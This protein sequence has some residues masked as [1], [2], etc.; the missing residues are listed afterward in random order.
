MN[1]TSP[2]SAPEKLYQKSLKLFDSQRFPEAEIAIAEAIDLDTQNSDYWTL[3]GKIWYMQ[4]RFDESKD[5]LSMALQLNVSNEIALEFMGSVV[6]KQNNKLEALAWF[7]KAFDITKQNFGIAHKLANHYFQEK[8]YPKAIYY[9]NECLKLKPQDEEIKM[10]MGTAFYQLGDRTKAL[11]IFS[12]VVLQNSNNINAKSS[13]AHCYQFY[14][15]TDFSEDGYKAILICLKTEKLAHRLLS[16]PWASL[17]ATNPEFAPFRKFTDSLHSKD[18][19]VLKNL[20]SEFLLLGL[21]K[22]YL[23][24]APTEIILTN[25]RRDLL[26]NWNFYKNNARELLPFLQALALVCWYNEFVF[27]QEND[28]KESLALLQTEILNIRQGQEL[29]EEQVAQFCLLCSYKP[30][31]SLGD[32]VQHIKLSK[33]HHYELKN[34]LKTQIKNPLHEIEVAQTIKGFTDISDETS[35][36]VRAMYEG[37]PYPRWRAVSKIAVGSDILERADNIDLLVAGCG[38]GHEPMQYAM[39]APRLKITAIDLSLASMAYG[40]RMAEEYGVKIIDFRHGDLMKVSDLNKKFDVITSSGVLHH[41]KEPEKG[42]EPLVKILKQGGRMSISLYSQTARD[43]VLNPAADYIVEKGY[44]KSE[45]DIRQFRKDI[46]ALPESDP[47]KLCQSSTDFYSLSECTDLL[48]HVQEH[49]YTFPKIRAMVEKYG[50]ELHH[51]MVESV[52]TKVY[53]EMFPDD[54]NMLNWDHWHEFEQKHPQTFA[55]MYK[56]WLKFKGDKSEH[57]MDPLIRIGLL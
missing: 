46:M 17:L 57:P 2:A 51:V 54:P 55:G 12:H 36:A 10:L 22:V 49:R 35:L 1:S 42:F 48:F 4:S 38:T 5:A 9:C 32:F 13:L 37:R 7:E 33:K 15:H 29:T 8:I 41:L 47:R 50:L 27:Y 14:Q 11:D 39:S 20:N 52:V 53:K 56:T 21:E 25:I 30:A 24:N 43:L 23:S 40:K 26:L 18:L 6:S 19:S 34:L 3:L 28:E 45:D 16:R 31:L 44:T